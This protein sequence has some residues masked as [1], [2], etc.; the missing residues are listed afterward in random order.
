MQRY[1]VFKSKKETSARNAHIFVLPTGTKQAA[2]FFQ[3]AA[4]YV[5]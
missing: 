3:V 4:R 1:K 5:Y 2:V